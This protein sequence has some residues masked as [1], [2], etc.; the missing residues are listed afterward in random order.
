MASPR[1][2]PWG[3]F[4][5][6]I[7]S[8]LA[9]GV[10]LGCAPGDGPAPE[11]KDVPM[12]EEPM[13]PMEKDAWHQAMLDTPKPGPGCWKAE[14]P[15]MEWVEVECVEMPPEPRLPKGHP[16]V[17]EPM[18]EEV[19]RGT[20]YAAQV[21]GS[22]NSVSGSFVDLDNVTSEYNSHYNTPNE[23]TLQL[24][25]SFWTGSPTCSGAG[26]EAWQQ[27]VYESKGSTGGSL[28]IQYW[29]LNYSGTCSTIGWWYGGGPG[30]CFVNSSGHQVPAQ[31]IASLGQMTLTGSAVA[32]GNDDTAL[33]VD[34]SIYSVQPPD[35]KLDLAGSWTTAEFNIFGNGN[36]T[37]AVFNDGASMTVNLVVRDGSTGAPSCVT[38]GYTAETNNLNLVSTPAIS[39]QTYPTVQ[40]RQSTSTGSASCQT[41]AGTSP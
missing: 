18:P 39:T 6:L 26:C 29:L 41:A 32:G 40:F 12:M 20:D 15:N 5:S 24:N 8:T 4:C 11:Q 33:H 25:T 38:A 35:S 14:H 17:I 19:G 37:S 22:L 16:G 7:L 2:R 3:L 30:L 13:A 36:G 21:S 27:F 9:L 10:L 28:Y 23:F 1:K 31:T 34:G